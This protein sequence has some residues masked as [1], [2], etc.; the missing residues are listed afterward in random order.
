MSAQFM[1]NA[2]GGL[3]GP[4]VFSFTSDANRSE[5]FLAANYETP[6]GGIPSY[7][8]IGTDR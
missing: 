8:D 4:S 2:K 3:I 7:G 1:L 6:T 5:Y